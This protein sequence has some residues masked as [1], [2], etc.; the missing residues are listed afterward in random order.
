VSWD[1]LAHLGTAQPV[2]VREALRHCA[3][4]GE[5]W[6]DYHALAQALPSLSR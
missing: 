3:Q 6:P 5:P 4:A 1:A 2:T